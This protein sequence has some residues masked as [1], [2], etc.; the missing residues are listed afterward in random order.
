MAT[1]LDLVNKV[2]QE[3]SGEIDELDSSTWSTAQ[4]GRRVYPRIKRN[5]ADAWKAIQVSRDEWE[6]MTTELS[7]V[8]Y[9]RIMV[10]EGARAAGQPPV[11]AVF[12]GR[13]SGFTFTV[14]AVDTAGS[15]TLGTAQGQIEF[16]DYTGQQLI[17]GEAFD[18]ISPVADDGVFTYLGK[19]SYSFLDI[20]EDLRA[21]QW[22]TFVAAMPN[23]GYRPVTYI[24][25]DNWFYREYNFTT[26]SQTA[27][28]LLSQDYAGNVVFYPQTFNPFR[29][30]FIYKLAPQILED[31][32]EEP[33]LIPEE[34]HDWIA[35]E[36]LKMLAMYD[37][38][39]TLY[40]YADKNAM[41]YKLKAEKN[42][43]PIISYRPSPFNV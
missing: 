29:V 36:A 6:F 34:Y 24:P 32:D 37:K 9:P 11:G 14:K 1:Y 43:L 2:I 13:E 21:I 28:S 16:E 19:G 15:W 22:A 25:W 12:E 5:V 20:D 26:S 31:Y 7:T 10:K 35:W 8:V 39:P 41:P 42:L 33:R 18:E 27:P 30:N 23:S 3:S 38:N 4:A 40:A 17:P